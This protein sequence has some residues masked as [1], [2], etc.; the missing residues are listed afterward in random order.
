MKILRNSQAQLKFHVSYEKERRVLD[1]SW[2]PIR[3]LKDPLPHMLYA[4][5]FIIL[6]TNENG[7]KPRFSKLVEFCDKWQLE[8]NINKSK[9]LIFTTPIE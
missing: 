6:F 3:L 9:I 5:D 1:E 4:D 2:D 7:L 8:L